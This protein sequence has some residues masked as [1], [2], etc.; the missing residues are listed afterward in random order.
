MSTCVFVCY[1]TRWYDISISGGGLYVWQ[2]VW[3]Q[4]REMFG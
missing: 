2:E 1:V 3:R 4:S